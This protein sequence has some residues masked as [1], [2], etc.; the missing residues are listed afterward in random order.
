MGAQK[1]KRI[2]NPLS[3]KI[4]FLDDRISGLETLDLLLPGFLRCYGKIRNSDNIWLF[5][6][7]RRQ[8]AADLPGILHAAIGD[9]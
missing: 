4:K 5:R 1:I 2:M 7:N 8:Q 9:V 6:I 3:I